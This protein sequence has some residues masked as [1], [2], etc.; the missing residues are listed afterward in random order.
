VLNTYP[1]WKNLLVVFAISLGVVYALP[2]IYQPDYAIQISSE[3][4]GV[5][6]TDRALKTAT[7]A[8]DAAGLNWVIETCSFDCPMTTHN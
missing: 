2:N 3:T 8:L 4:S 6:V 7:D 1:L 5:A